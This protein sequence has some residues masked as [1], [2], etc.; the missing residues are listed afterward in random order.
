MASK[1]QGQAGR[2]RSKRSK[3]LPSWSK[4]SARSWLLSSRK[5]RLKTQ[6]NTTFTKSLVEN[7]EGFPEAIKFSKKNPKLGEGYS[8]PLRTYWDYGCG[9]NSAV[10][11][12]T[13]FDGATMQIIMW[14]DPRHKPYGSIQLSFGF[15]RGRSQFRLVLAQL[16]RIQNS[17]QR[18]AFSPM[19]LAATEIIETM[20]SFPTWSK[21]HCLGPMSCI[22][23]AESTGFPDRTRMRPFFIFPK[24]ENIP[25]R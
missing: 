11:I 12:E 15:R 21:F 22:V 25:K 20:W 18:S 24:T 3:K 1:A 2:P 8:A 23:S 17:S 5:T 16:S 7:L 19:P 4:W 9:K 6:R 14:S 13:S 10:S